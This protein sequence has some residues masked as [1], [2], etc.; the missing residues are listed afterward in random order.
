MCLNHTETT[1]RP[2]PHPHGKIIFQETGPWCQKCWG[3]LNF[4]GHIND[5]EKK[6]LFKFKIHTPKCIF[7]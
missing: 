1:P 3:L 4:T 5:P 7:N 6:N 2:R